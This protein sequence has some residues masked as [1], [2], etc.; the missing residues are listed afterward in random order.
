[1]KFGEFPRWLLQILTRVPMNAQARRKLK[2]GLPGTLV[3]TSRGNCTEFKT[4]ENANQLSLNHRLN[5]WV[6]VSN[7][8]WKDLLFSPLCRLCFRNIDSI[9]QRNWIASR[10]AWEE[11]LQSQRATKPKDNSSKNWMDLRRK[12]QNSAKWYES[13]NK[14]RTPLLSEKSK[15]CRCV[16]SSLINDKLFTIMKNFFFGFDRALGGRDW[17]WPEGHGYKASIQAGGAMGCPRSPEWPRGRRRRVRSEAAG[18]S[19]GPECARP[20]NLSGR[21]GLFPQEQWEVIKGFSTVK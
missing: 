13:M 8:R 18:S 11:R 9:K 2:L 3:V 19:A 15:H 20:G 17:E 10:S 5:R 6:H 4:S 12:L 21:V 1:M 16:H 7:C 14:W